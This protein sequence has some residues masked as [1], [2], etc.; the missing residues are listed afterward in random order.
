MVCFED[1]KVKDMRLGELFSAGGGVKRACLTTF[2]EFVDL[3]I[4][5]GVKQRILDEFHNDT[6]S[7]YESHDTFDLIH[8]GVPQLVARANN[9]RSLNMLISEN[10]LFIVYIPWSDADNMR[11]TLEGILAK[12]TSPGRCAVALLDIFTREDSNVLQDIEENITDV[13][14]DLITAYDNDY[15]KDIIG[16][17]KKLLPLKRYYEQLVDLFDGL[18]DNDNDFL[19]ESGL[20]Y[21]GNVANR[22]DRLYHAVQNLRDYVTQVREAYQS[23]A[24]INLNVIMKV[25]TVITAIFL[26]L[27]LIVGWYGMNL[28]MPEF[29]WDY[30]YPA[31]IGL[32]ALVVVLCI[33]LFKKNK[34]F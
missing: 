30:G 13:E 10:L 11:S 15:L 14:D 12:N 3:D 16:F 7:K 32:C 24:D 1:G 18:N 2:N 6:I 21:C 9:A 34:W 25:F 22:A 27:T 31:V 29:N 20:K 4:D 26:P 5:G 23:Q 17:R 33:V 28:K 19:D 8:L